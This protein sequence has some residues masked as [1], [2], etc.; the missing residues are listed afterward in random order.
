MLSFVAMLDMNIVNVALPDIAASFAVSAPVAQWVV[1]GYQLA[2]VALLLPAGG[3]L[4]GAGLRS[5]LLFSVSGFGLASAAAALAP[6]IGVLVVVRAVQGAFG[7]I[8]FVLMPVA[9]ARSVRPEVRGRAMSV[10]ATLGPLGAVTG[11]AVGG[12]LL[13]LIGWR[14]I[15][16]V[17]IPICV[18][19]LVLAWRNA[20]GGGRLPRPD[21]RAVVDAGLIGTAVCLVLLAFTLAPLSP[22]WLALAPLSIVPLGLWVRGPDGARFTATVRQARLVGLAGA[23]FGVAAGFAAMRYVVALHLQD[24][25]GVSASVTGLTLLAFPL[26]MALGGPLGGRLADRFGARLLAPAGAAITAAGL[27][28]LVFMGPKWTPLDVVW[29]LAVAGAGMGLYGG[30]V[31]LLAMTRAGPSRMATTGAAAQLARSLGFTIGP[32]LAT[33]ASGLV[34]G[35]GGVRGGLLAAALAA[36][37]ALVLLVSATRS[38]APG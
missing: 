14:A 18:V 23:V 27:L 30:P 28:L 16:F 21:R 8:M 2:V 17:K 38:R 33:V 9:A 32:A 7:A 6:S 13:D 19:A 35:Y 26:A 24:D 5:A 20:P 1:L 15:F 29:R 10:P 25:Q 12:V 37:F 3:W 34:A 11:P 4:D 36:C 31:N 22:A